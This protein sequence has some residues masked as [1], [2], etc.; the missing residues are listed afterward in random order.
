MGIRGNLLLLAAI[1]LAFTSCAHAQIAPTGTPLPSNDWSRVSTPTQGNPR[2]I[3]FYSNGCIAGAATLPL[4]GD[5]YQ[6]MR[7]YRNR[8]Y[9]QP[10][11]IHFIQNLAT[12][13]HA[14]GS[15]ILVGDLGQPR[16]GTMPYGHASHQIGL[17]VDI[18][19]WAHPE[20]N[21]RSLTVDERNNLPMPTV[22][23]SNGLVDETKFTKE[24]ILKLKVAALSPRVER[25][26]VNPAIKTY[27]C[28]KLPTS[29]LPWLHALRPWTGHDDHFH[30]RL[31]C[32]VGSTSCTAQAPQ[33]PGDGCNELMP[34]RGLDL[35]LT[36]HNEEASID[37]KIEK[38]LDS[39]AGAVL[40]AECAKILKE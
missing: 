33:A 37:P 27:L 13:V 36:H 16:G 15:A 39:P 30:V 35:D 26:F 9:G 12:E 8:N 34:P 32:P 28:S 29:E 17:D 38:L 3:G 5:G 2:S 23:N 11:L 1:S 10:D 6:V 18:W 4:D 7:V 22:L 14:Y 31:S 20:Q 40:P 21:N 19:Y 24:I 25:I